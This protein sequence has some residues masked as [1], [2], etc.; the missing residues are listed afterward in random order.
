MSVKDPRMNVVIVSGKVSKAYEERA[1][2]NGEF[3]NGKVSIEI[4]N[5]CYDK[6]TQKKEYK[7]ITIEVKVLGRSDSK[8][9]SPLAVMQGLKLGDRAVFTGCFEGDFWTYEGRE[10]SKV[11]IQASRIQTFESEEKPAA[12]PRPAAPDNEEIPED[13]IPF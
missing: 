11:F 8:P 3:I 12:K 2:A 6:A 10:C 13:D 5:L 9:G 1:S 4:F 7:P